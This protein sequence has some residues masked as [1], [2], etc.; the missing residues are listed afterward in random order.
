VGTLTTA[1]KQLIMEFPILQENQ[2]AVIHAEK[3]TG[4]VLDLEYNLY[5]KDK[6][7]SVY[8]IFESMQLAEQYIERI[9]AQRN[10]LE[11][12]VYDRNESVLKI[13]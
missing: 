12:V 13:L 8:S 1:D 5:R 3:A 9:K 2:V 4:H 10:D 7:K 11:F 6:P